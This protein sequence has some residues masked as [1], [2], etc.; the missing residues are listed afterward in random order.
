MNQNQEK[1]N[2]CFVESKYCLLMGM[3]DSIGGSWI[4]HLDLECEC[5]ISRLISQSVFNDINV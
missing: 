1:M 3:N 5:W 2:N 4:Q